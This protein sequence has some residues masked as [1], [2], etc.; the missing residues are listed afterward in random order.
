MLLRPRLLA[1]AL[2]WR[3]ALLAAWLLLPSTLPAARLD[4]RRISLGTAAAPPAPSPSARPA[5]Y[6]GSRGPFG[7][8]SDR[9]QAVEATGASPSYGLIGAPF[10]LA[11]PVIPLEQPFFEG[12]FDLGL[13]RSRLFRPDSWPVRPDGL[14]RRIGIGWFRFN[15]T[16]R[17]E[18]GHHLGV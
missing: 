4:R 3:L 6:V 1:G 17:L 5:G 8:N 2:L 12:P 14:R 13:R 10:V 11:N 18:I 9:R 15:H 7:A 16:F